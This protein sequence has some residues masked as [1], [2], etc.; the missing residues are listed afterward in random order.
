MTYYWIPFKIV[1]VAKKIYVNVDE[2]I[3][4]KTS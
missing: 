2:I 3:A 4:I 1:V